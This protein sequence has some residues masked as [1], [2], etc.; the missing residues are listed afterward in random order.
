ME[1]KADQQNKNISQELKEGLGYLGT[2]RLTKQGEE[3]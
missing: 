1:R 2:A 3:R